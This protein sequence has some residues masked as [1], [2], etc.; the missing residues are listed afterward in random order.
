[1]T[2]AAGAAAETSASF[3]NG[4]GDNI[5]EVKGLVKHFP[6]MAGLLKRNDRRGAGCRRPTLQ[7]SAAR[8]HRRQ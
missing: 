2:E 7:S 6:I 4:L 1:V 8:R 3:S 5:L